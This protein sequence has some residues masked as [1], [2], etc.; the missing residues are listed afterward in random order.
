MG[1]WCGHRPWHRWGPPWYGYGPGPGF[2][3]GPGFARGPRRRR[4]RAEELEAYVRDLEEELA[5][6]KAELED[7]RE[8]GTSQ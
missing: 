1:C 5:T 2:G 4:T 8:G 3:Y 6:V 7:L